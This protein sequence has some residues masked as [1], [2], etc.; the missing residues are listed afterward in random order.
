MW[1]HKAS[2]IDNWAMKGHVISDKELIL[3]N[4]SS[5]NRKFLIENMVSERYVIKRKKL[6]W[7]SKTF[8]QRML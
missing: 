8:L 3:G 5:F 2:L 6:M 7:E 4:K 1:R